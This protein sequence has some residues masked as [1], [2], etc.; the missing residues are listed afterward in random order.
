MADETYSR[1]KEPLEFSE[2]ESEDLDSEVSG[3]FFDEAYESS[4]D[5]I[6]SIDKDGK[7]SG[8]LVFHDDGS[9]ELV[10]FLYHPNGRL[11]TQI[12]SGTEPDGDSYLYITDFTAD[13]A[14]DSIG[15]MHKQGLNEHSYFHK[16]RGAVSV[17]DQRIDD[18]LTTKAE[19]YKDVGTGRQSLPAMMEQSK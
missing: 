17:Y 11:Q 4:A 6:V 10:D 15:T 12:V 8:T 16:S 18:R 5:R 9:M 7:V 14:L 19:N 3:K 1:H 2:T 13:G